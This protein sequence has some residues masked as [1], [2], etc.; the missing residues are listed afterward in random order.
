MGNTSFI[1]LTCLSSVLHLLT[2]TSD[3]T[4]TCVFFMDSNLYFNTQTNGKQCAM[5]IPTNTLPLFQSSHSTSSR[6]RNVFPGKAVGRISPRIAN[7]A[8][9]SIIVGI[10]WSKNRSTHLLVCKNTQFQNP[11]TG[12]CLSDE[13]VC[14]VEALYVILGGTHWGWQYTR[15]LA[16]PPNNKII[17]DVCSKIPYKC[18]TFKVCKVCILLF[19][20][21]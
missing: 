13:S 5:C 11:V 18:N 8:I 17:L 21:F 1:I 10:C 3:S 16:Q 4:K 15:H 19:S 7:P 6:T 9:K 14:P 12:V 2:L 20:H